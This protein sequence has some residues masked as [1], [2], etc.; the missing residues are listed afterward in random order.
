MNRSET[1]M[2]MKEDTNIATMKTVANSTII[3]FFTKVACVKIIQ[4][5]EI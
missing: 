4:G 3:S 1:K 2:H 5:M